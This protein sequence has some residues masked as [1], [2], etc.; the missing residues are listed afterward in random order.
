MR[1]RERHGHPVNG[2]QLLVLPVALLFGSRSIG[3]IDC[4]SAEHGRGLIV[5]PNGKFRDQPV[6]QPIGLGGGLDGVNRCSL[7]HDNPVMLIEC[8]RDVGRE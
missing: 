1:L 7:L 2:L 8:R 6:A 3:D 4:H 5:E